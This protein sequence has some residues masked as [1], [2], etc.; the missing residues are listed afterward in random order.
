M[1]ATTRIDNNSVSVNCTGGCGQSFTLPLTV[2]QETVWRKGAPIQNVAPAVPADERELRISGTCSKCWDAL[3][4][5]DE[6][7]AA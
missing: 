3:F 2:E 6:N 4:A 5:D 7:E 1:Q